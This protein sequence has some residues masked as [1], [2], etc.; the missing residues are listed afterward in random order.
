MRNVRFTLPDEL[1]KD[2]KRKAIDE[3]IPL[4]GLVIK[5]LQE[6]INKH[7]PLAKNDATHVPTREDKE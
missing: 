4:K 2:L 5:A 1:H 3:S 7:P 6:Y